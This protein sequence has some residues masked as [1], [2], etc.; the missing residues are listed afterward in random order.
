MNTYGTSASTVYHTR[1]DY[2]MSSKDSKHGAEMCQTKREREMPQPP[3][4][5]WVS[6]LVDQPIYV[7]RLIW[8]L[9]ESNFVT[10]VVP[11]SSFGIL[12]ALAAPILA[13]GPHVRVVDVLMRVPLVVLFNWHNVLNFDLANQRWPESVVE[14]RLNKPW[15]PIVTGKLTMDQAR[16]SMLV[17]IPSALLVNYALGVWRQGVFILILTWLYNDIRG[18]DE[19]VRDLIISIAYGL[20]NS[21]SLEIALGGQ[22]GINP[23]GVV[24]TAIISGVILTTMQ[25]Q[26]LKDQAGDQTRGR[27]TIPLFLGDTVSRVSI[28]LFV[29]LWSCICPLFWQVGL[30]GYGVSGVLGALVAI[31]V[32]LKRNP[33]DDA[34][35][36]KWWCFW[37]M[38]LY[39]QPAVHLVGL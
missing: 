29:I 4:K 26:D 13:S 25:I 17:T 1:P 33:K 27:K 37:T 14:D 19:V 5:G 9:T 20:F 21:A 8:D 18:G 39:L 23:D 7:I 16:R 2:T 30:F 35:S 12:G 10:F 3:K 15:R 6:N 22:S 11:C 34:L 32:S 36:W 38:A 28:V 24:W 31:R